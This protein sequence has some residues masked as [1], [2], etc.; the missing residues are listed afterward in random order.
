[1]CE[2][3]RW[4]CQL[5]GQQEGREFGERTRKRGRGRLDVRRR[6]VIPRDGALRTCIDGDDD[7]D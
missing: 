5:G 2:I 7:L 1:M 3:D 6:R 4:L